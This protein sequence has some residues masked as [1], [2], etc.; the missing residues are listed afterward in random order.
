[1]TSLLAGAAHLPA[2]LVSAL[3]TGPLHALGPDWLNADHL[4][5]SFGS[6]AL[7][8]VVIVVFIETGLLFPLLPGD[9][10]LFT[11]GALVAQKTLDFPLWLLCLLIFLAA[12]AGDQNAYWIG[13][14]LGPRVFN[15]PDSR[16]FKREHIDETYRYFEKYGPMTVVVARFVPFVRTYASVAAGVGRM[17]YA[18][19]VAFDLMGALLWGVGVTMLGY[20]LG[21]VPFVKDNI[22]YLLVVVVGLSVI[23]IALGWLRSRL[24]KRRAAAAGPADAAVATEEKPV[25]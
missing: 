23:P 9:S 16:I 15:R 13:R 4:I 8:G 21:N 10:L 20:A 7:I 14:K 2:A 19:F 17:R 22:E 12:F 24:T 6:Y 1:M 11:A 25:S 3:P 5:A 18:T